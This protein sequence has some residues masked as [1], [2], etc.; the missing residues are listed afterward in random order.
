M[1][2]PTERSCQPYHGD[3]RTVGHFALHLAKYA[4]E[5]ATAAEKMEHEMEHAEG[6][7]LLR[8]WLDR[9]PD[10]V[11][12]TLDLIAEVADHA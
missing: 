8:S 5:L 1:P 9:R 10:Q 7:R 3:V 12:R 2:E 11:R 6:E 4:G